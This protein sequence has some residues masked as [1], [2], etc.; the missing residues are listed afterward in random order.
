[1]ARLIV[2][3]PNW[4]GDAVLALP[5]IAAVRRAAPEARL[6]VAARAPIA[7]LFG[8]VPGIDDVHVLEQ[9]G[10]QSFSKPDE[11]GNGARPHSPTAILLP[12]SFQTALLAWRSGI[13]ERWGYRTDWRGPLLTRAVA[14][15]SAVHQVDYYQ[16]LVAALGFPSS[17]AEP[18]LA[19]SNELRQTGVRVLKD[20]GWDARA[21]LV[22]LAPGA[23]YG[24][25]KRWPARS[26]AELA[27]SLAEDGVQS[28]LV[29]SRADLPVAREIEDALG[30]GQA[31]ATVLNLMGTDLPTLAAM[32]AACRA[33]VSNDSGAMHLAAAVGVR[34][35]AVFGPTDER[36]TRPVGDAHV[37]IT[38]QVW[39]RPCMMRECPID[40]RCMRRIA[41]DRV[42][43]A[44]RRLL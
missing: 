12:N 29:G 35:V 38:H 15:P 5:A 37:V 6:T 33:V 16:R 42:T 26:F 36:R 14:P 30:A 24:G 19:L 10:R 28:V 8:M 34:V 17:P 31:A 41:P 21:P 22:A 13:P 4:L 44:L 9:R 1:M 23:A 18:H 11:G 39:C 43:G 27:R 40:H 2:F 25:A 3:A 32:L 20:A 7:P